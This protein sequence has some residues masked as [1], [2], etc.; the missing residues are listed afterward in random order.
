MK[1]IV[2]LAGGNDFSRYCMLTG[3]I[4]LACIKIVSTDIR[5]QTLVVDI[6]TDTGVN[7]IREIGGIVDT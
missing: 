1:K 4:V 5:E 6:Q 2:R 7:F 3:Q